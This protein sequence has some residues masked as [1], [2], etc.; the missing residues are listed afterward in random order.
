M[1]DRKTTADE[2]R[3]M[4][5]LDTV[6]SEAMAEEPEVSDALMARV[7]ADA[8]RVQAALQARDA[9]PARPRGRGGRLRA[10]VAALGGWGAM[11]GLL[12]ATVAGFWIGAFPPAALDAYVDGQF[13]DSVSVGFDPAADWIG[14]EG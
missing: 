5:L 7:L 6:L 9:V 12:T 11:G 13:G 2:T 10:I 14:E 8:D 1:T 4:A 3:D